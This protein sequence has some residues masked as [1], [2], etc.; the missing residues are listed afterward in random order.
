MSRHGPIR[1][2]VDDL[3]AEIVAWAEA[4]AIPLSTALAGNGFA[5]LE[6]LHEKIGDARVVALGE[7]THGSREVFRVKHRFVEFLASEMDFSQ[8]EIEANMPEARC[9]NQFPARWCRHLKNTHRLLPVDGPVA[10]STPE[11]VK[12]FFCVIDR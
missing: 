5:D 10:Y 2:K 1:Q 11:L 8:F 4:N 6:A 7:T 9:L 3:P 12:S